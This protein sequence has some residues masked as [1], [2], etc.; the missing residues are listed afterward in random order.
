MSGLNWLDD[1]LAG[2]ERDGLLRVPAASLSAPGPIVTRSDG[3][4]YLN[5]CSNDY[6]SLASRPAAGGAGA[7]ASRLIAGDLAVHREL[8]TALAAWLGTEAAL[9][10]SSGYAANVGVLSSLAGSDTLIVSDALNHA[11]IVDGCRLS[12]ARVV[13][14][15]HRD[16]AA[17]ERAL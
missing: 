12:R 9:V 15:P 13:V 16:L 8:E 10:F 17:V 3:R 7:G 14:T 5:L 2:L 11:S 6:L 1:A 4:T